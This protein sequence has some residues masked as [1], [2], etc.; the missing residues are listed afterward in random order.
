MW[1]HQYRYNTVVQVLTH[2]FLEY[3]VIDVVAEVC[4]SCLTTGTRNQSV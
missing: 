1:H 4:L 2:L 3:V